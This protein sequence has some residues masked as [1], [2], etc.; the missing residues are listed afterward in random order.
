[1]SCRPDGLQADGP[2]AQARRT[3]SSPV[4]YPAASIYIN[5]AVAV[6]VDVENDVEGSKDEQF[7]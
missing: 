2:L 4:S 3:A 1:M 7:N 6:A 5:V